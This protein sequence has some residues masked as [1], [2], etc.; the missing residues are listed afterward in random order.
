MSLV[1]AGLC[2]LA[3]EGSLGMGGMDTANGVPGRSNMPGTQVPEGVTTKVQ[4]ACADLGTGAHPGAAPIRRLTHEEFN[5]TVRDLLNTQLRPGDNFPDEARALGFEGIAEAQTVTVLLAENYQSAAKI[6]AEEATRDL[7]AL[8]GCEPTAGTC[9]DDFVTKFGGL[10]YRRP[11]TPLE[12]TDLLAIYSWGKDNVSEREGVMMLLEVIFQ[13]PDFLYRPE[14]GADEIE[15]GVVRLTSWEMANRLSYLFTGSLPDEE[16][17]TIASADALTT[18]EQVQVQAERLMS[19]N[20]LREIFHRFFGQWLDLEAV[21]HLERD[22]EVYPGYTE[23]IPGLLRQETEAFVDH[24]MFEDDGRLETL[25]TAPYTL[26][27]AEL[28]SFYGVPAPLEPGFSPVE[29]PGH[30]GLLT[31]GSILA[32]HAKPLQTSPVARGKFIRESVL[33]QILSPPPEDLIVTAPDLD[34]TLST[35]ERFAAH[36]E[37]P[38][39]SGCHQLM[40][41][42]GLGF[43]G[44]DPVG[45]IRETENGIPVDTSGELVSADQAGPYVGPKELADKLAKSADVSSCMTQNWVRFAYGKSESPKDACSLLKIDSAFVASDYH[46]P[47]LVLS[48][49][50]TDAFLY[51]EVVTP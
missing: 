26:V 27:N 34:P 31:Q 17:R 9:V 23:Q 14:F 46:I 12:K 35:R 10:A 20:N 32:H 45:R 13:S 4:Q 47:T 24:V 19:E 25:L 36:T 48:L 33:C 11:L 16:L 5:R 18:P 29:I 22:P 7:P 38:G 42:L 43:E 50:Q 3:C 30:V 2:C 44:F 28:A 37:E 8:L 6:L 1:F 49:T 51:R 40:D 39:C 41:P 21:A 15:P